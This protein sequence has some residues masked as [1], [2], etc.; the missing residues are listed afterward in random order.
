ML[1]SM[2]FK[3]AFED[4]RFIGIVK[5]LGWLDNLSVWRIFVRLKK[6]ARNHLINKEL[7]LIREFCCH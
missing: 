1:A 2:Y 5:E 3:L 6:Q 4:K 7:Q